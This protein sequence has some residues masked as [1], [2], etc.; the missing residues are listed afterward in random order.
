MRFATALVAL[1]A[2]GPV[3]SAPVSSSGRVARG[4]DSVEGIIEARDNTNSLHRRTSH[5]KPPAEVAPPAG[6]PPADPTTAD[7]N[8]AVPTAVPTADPIASDVFIP[9]P[10][11]PKT[12]DNKVSSEKQATRT[13]LANPLPSALLSH[14][15]T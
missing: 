1:A 10:N 13:Y 5:P 12:R 7:P 2:A 9:G 4:H 8:A 11:K 3:L 6:V 15:L 14:H